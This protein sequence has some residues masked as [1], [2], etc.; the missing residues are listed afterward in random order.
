MHFQIFRHGQ[1]AFHLFSHVVICREKQSFACVNSALTLLDIKQVPCYPGDSRQTNAYIFLITAWFRQYS[2]A[3]MY[4][5]RSIGTPE[6]PCSLPTAF[7]II[8]MGFMGS[9]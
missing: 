1:P 5:S 6:P 9:S 8:V 7:L 3:F 4:S 2:T